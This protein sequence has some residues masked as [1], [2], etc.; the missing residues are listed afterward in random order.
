M[1]NNYII[2]DLERGVLGG[3]TNKMFS[4]KA[5]LDMLR[6]VV[7]SLGVIAVVMVIVFSLISQVKATQTDKTTVAYG[8]INATEKAAAT[9]PTWLPIIILTIVGGI[10]LFYVYNFMGGRNK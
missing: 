6:S 2:L 3:V 1:F 5:S 10:C 9:I 7:L 4:K 8:A